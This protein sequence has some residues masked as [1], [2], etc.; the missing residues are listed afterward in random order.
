MQLHPDLP[1]GFVEQAKAIVA[2]VAA[3]ILH[4]R[5]G[6]TMGKVEHK[7]PRDLVSYVDRQSELM[8]RERFEAL[9]PGSGFLGEET[10][11][12][13]NQHDWLWIVDPLDGTT[14][15][16]HN[17]PAYCISVGLR[18]REEMVLG[19]VHEV[20]HGEVFWAVKGHGA[21]LGDKRIHV[22]EAASINDALLATGFPTAKFDRASDYLAAVQEFLGQCQGIRRFGAAALDLAYVAAG[23]LDGF[24]EIGLKPWDVAGGALIVTEAGGSVSGIEPG[25]DYL[26]GRQIAVSNGK[27]Q[28]T[29][30]E[31]LRAHLVR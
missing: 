18:H 3:F 29:M 5:E 14:N 13:G 7:G 30:L 10:G 9:L 8:L 2:E 6:F 22:S 12:H 4:E 17:I 19:I 1:D 20:P 11:E 21:Y 26:F 25:G 28:Q 31:V 24:F 27:L 16:I 23:R 15:F